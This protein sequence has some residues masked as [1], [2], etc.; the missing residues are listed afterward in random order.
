MTAARNNEYSY[1]PNRA[2]SRAQAKRLRSTSNASSSAWDSVS[3]VRNGV[4]EDFVK[5]DYLYRNRNVEVQDDPYADL[6]DCMI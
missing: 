3:D 1:D 6:R 2:R 5:V 4:K